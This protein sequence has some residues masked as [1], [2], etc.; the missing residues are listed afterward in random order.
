[1]REQDPILITRY[2]KII[3]KTQYRLFYPQIYIPYKMFCKNIKRFKI[4]DFVSVIL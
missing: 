4:D 1:M 3:I 2:L